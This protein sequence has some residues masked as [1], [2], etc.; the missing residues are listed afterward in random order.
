MKFVRPFSYPFVE[1]SVAT[2]GRV[3]FLVWILLA[4]ALISFGDVCLEKREGVASVRKFGG[5][6]VAVR[7]ER[8]DLFSGIIRYEMLRSAGLLLL[9]YFMRGILALRADDDIFAPGRKIR[10][11]EDEQP[12]SD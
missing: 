6:T 11:L 9:C 5:A 4:G 7:D 8:P 1:W 12:P 2:A 3:R 10:S